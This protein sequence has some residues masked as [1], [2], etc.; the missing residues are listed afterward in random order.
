MLTF[1]NKILQ[2]FAIVSVKKIFA[3]LSNVVGNWLQFLAIISNQLQLFAFVINIQQLCLQLKSNKLS[4][5]HWT[6][7]ATG[8]SLFWSC[9]S[10]KLK[11]EVNLKSVSMRWGLIFQKSKIRR[12]EKWCQKQRIIKTWRSKGNGKEVGNTSWVKSIHVA[13]QIKVWKFANLIWKVWK[14]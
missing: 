5:F 14:G 4:Q 6:Y 7:W 13:L 8:L 9:M 10:H 11:S 12:I 1:V 3:N 2:S